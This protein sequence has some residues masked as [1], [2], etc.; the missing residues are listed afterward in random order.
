MT[1]KFKAL[2][3]ENIHPMAK[4]QLEEQGIEVTLLKHAPP[5]DELI[6]LLQGFD[7]VGLRSKTKITS[8]VLDQTNLSAVCCY[9]IGTNQVDLVHANKLGVPVFNAPHS[10]TRSVAELMI[11]HIVALSRQI[12]DRNMKAHQG[13]W[14]KSAIGANEIRGKI[15]GIIGYGHIGSQVS[16]LA[17]S[18]GM[19]VQYYDI[20]KKLPLGNASQVTSLKELLN[21][22]D[23]VT[24]HVP[25][26]PETIN[27]FGKNE[28]SMMKKG[29]Y[30][31]N[32]ARGST[33]IIED[34]AQTLKSGHLAG[35]AIDVFP[36]EPRN[37]TESFS[38]P[39]QGLP[40]VILTPHIGGST[41]EAQLNIG[42]EVSESMTKFLKAGATVGAVNFP[43]LDI[44]L[45]S[46]SARVVNVHKNEP[47][48]LGQI[49]NI[50]S[51]EGIN[52][53]GQYLSTDESIGYLIMDVHTD[54]AETI[55]EEINKINANIKTRLIGQ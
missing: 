44:A 21:T 26:T 42:I 13:I 36:K 17:E 1:K 5:E 40:N 43:Q 8:K 53:D 2:L 52:I 20:V 41:E 15:L 54:H 23:F 18:M 49:N 27:M 11:S 9:C 35:C 34:L 33:I 22:S 50:I 28:L 3:L 45:K 31:I 10:N 46:D 19:K 47:G 25:E 12:G 32:A 30:L 4:V 39:L 51:H 29:S 16:V 14:D 37:P 48:V 7:T 55:T 38:S 24:L 6:D